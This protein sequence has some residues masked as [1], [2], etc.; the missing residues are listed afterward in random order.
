MTFGDPIEH[1]RFIH[2]AKKA[3]DFLPPPDTYKPQFNRTELQRF[4]DIK[5][6]KG[7]K[8]M[9]PKILVTNVL[10][11][12]T[13][14]ASNPVMKDSLLT[15]VRSLLASKPDAETTPPPNAYTLP[16]FTDNLQMKIRCRL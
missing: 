5:L 10:R 1:T 13:P 9:E 7:A 4:R 15:Q 8:R 6:D 16:T 14:T 2:L 11:H 12:S 3:K